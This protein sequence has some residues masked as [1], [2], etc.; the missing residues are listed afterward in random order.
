MPAASTGQQKRPNSAWPT[1]NHMSHNQHFK[2]WMNWAM[3]FC[4]ILYIHLTSLRLVLQTSWPFLAGKMLPQPAG[5][6]KSFPRVCWLSKHG[7]LWY[8]NKFI[9]CWQ[10]CACNGSYF[11]M[12]PHYNGSYFDYY[13]KDV[14]EP[15]YNN[16]NY[17]L[18]LQLRLYQS[19]KKEAIWNISCHE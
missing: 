17:S 12:V 9:S 3:K 16:L 1:P 7:F 8:R 10:K 15:S 14:F 13:N 18:K 11:V 6:R 2:I 4:L 5:G 19:K